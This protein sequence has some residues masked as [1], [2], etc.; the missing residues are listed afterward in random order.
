MSSLKNYDVIG[1]MLS[2]THRTQTKTIVGVPEKKEIITRE[3][4]DKWEEI[5]PNGTI[6]EWE[7]KKGYRVKRPKNL[8][9]L[10][11]IRNSLYNYEQCY[12][13]C[14]KRKTKKYTKYDKETCTI[15]KMCLDCL[16]RYE[17]LLKINGEFEEY[18][19][20]KKIQSLQD[21]FNE[22]EKE[23]EIIKESLR[24]IEYINEDGSREKWNIENKKAFLEK[25]D[26]DFDKL[27]Q[28]LLDPLINP[29]KKN[30]H[31]DI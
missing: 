18:E 7:Q 29:D 24:T 1:K 4:G 15:H 8:E 5:L 28:S 11:N 21:F 23:K 19:R 13:N 14:E 31:H 22:A 30:N 6:I 26:D 3:I 16:S 10:L 12:E 27:K 20:L 17:T 25:I 9:S 2:G